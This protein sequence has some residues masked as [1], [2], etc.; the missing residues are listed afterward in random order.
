MVNTLFKSKELI[1]GWY[2]QLCQLYREQLNM[3]V[4]IEHKNE[5]EHKQIIKHS[6]FWG[7]RMGLRKGRADCCSSSRKPLATSLFLNHMYVLL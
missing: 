2:I 6:L 7:K 4:L 5:Y 3:A 1:E